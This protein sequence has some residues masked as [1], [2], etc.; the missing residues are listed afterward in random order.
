MKKNEAKA[1]TKKLIEKMLLR[2]FNG[3]IPETTLLP[4]LNDIEDVYKD[5]EW[6]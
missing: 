5:V 6:D 2:V 3:S 4:L 1:K